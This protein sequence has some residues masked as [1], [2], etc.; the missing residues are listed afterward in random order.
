MKGDDGNLIGDG[1]DIKMVRG[2]TRRDFIKYSAATV[3]GTYIAGLSACTGGG[4]DTSSNSNFPVL[5]FSDV[6]FSPFYDKSLFPLLM[7]AD[8]GKWAGIFQTSSITTPSTWGND[9]NYPLLVLALAS[10][11]QNLGSCPLVIFTGDIL[12]HN[13]PATFF[14]LYGSK[15][16]AALQAFTDKTVSFFMGQV[17]AA[18]GNIPVM[19]AVGNLDSYTGLGPD[20]IFLASNAELFYTDFLNSTTDRQTFMNTFTA[21]GYYSCQ[22]LGTNLL[23]IGINTVIC[24]ALLPGDNSSAVN[25]EMAWLDSQLASAKAHGQQVWLLMHVPPGADITT[26]ASAVVSKGLP[27]ETASA[28]MMWNSTYQA[29]FLNMLAKYP[30]LITLTLAA[31]THMDEYRIMSPGN[32]LEIT[33]AIAP[34]FGNNPAFKI[35]TFSSG[36]FRPTDYSSLNYDLSTLPG[37]FNSY[38]T[39]SAA[40]SA[41]NLLNT[42]L[43]QLDPLLVTNKALQDLYR[44]YYFSGHNYSVPLPN[45]LDPITNTNWPVFWSGIGNMDVTSL[46]NSI[47]SYKNNF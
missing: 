17:R 21:G 40:Y 44:G 35:F 27:L 23:V 7:A 3:A 26:T 4:N 12:G 16:L 2:I 28:S 46:V 24:G 41:R 25:A 37:R 15:D 29:S 18:V 47:N 36:T 45:T 22:P 30:G 1:G 39:F 32:V 5:V 20:S 10:I 13:I 11:N 6:H 8:A 38:Y 9:S 33:P 14:S 19:F 43:E 42:S 34:Y 31:H